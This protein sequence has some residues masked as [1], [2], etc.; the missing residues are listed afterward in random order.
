[1]GIN[2]S[3]ALGLAHWHSISARGGSKSDL[4]MLEMQM[5]CWLPIADI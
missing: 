4:F 5:N 1:M 2:V 3:A